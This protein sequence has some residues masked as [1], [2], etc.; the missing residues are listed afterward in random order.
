MEKLARCRVALFRKDLP[1]VQSA[2]TH[3]EHTVRVEP[4]T[5]EMLDGQPSHFC[6][7]EALEHDVRKGLRK[8]VVGG[9]FLANPPRSGRVERQSIVRAH[10]EHRFHHLFAH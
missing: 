6:R 8:A 9:E 3:L 4:L 2:I 7:Q 10:G 5:G 1:L